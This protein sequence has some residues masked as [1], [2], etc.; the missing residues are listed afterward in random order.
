MKTGVI[1]DSWGTNGKNIT[2]WEHRV[3]SILVYEDKFFV[4][5]HPLIRLV[6]W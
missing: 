5:L 2:L 1:L 6:N 4:L 3:L